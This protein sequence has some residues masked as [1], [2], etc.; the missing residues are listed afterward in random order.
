MSAVGTVSVAIMIGKS[1]DSPVDANKSL[2][3]S[4]SAKKAGDGLDVLGAGTDRRAAVAGI[5]D[6][7]C[8]AGGLRRLRR[9]PESM[10]ELPAVPR[11]HYRFC[12]M[13]ST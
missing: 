2:S 13:G 12:P 7:D 3:S 11:H 1:G 5:I 4:A 9:L 6:L 10:S 8:S